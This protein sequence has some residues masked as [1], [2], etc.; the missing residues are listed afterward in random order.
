[1]DV[2][3]HSVGHGGVLLLNSTPNTSGLIPEGDLQ[4][5]AA[6][7]REIERRF[8]QPIMEVNDQRGST[9]ELALPQ[10]TLIN[11]AVI[12]EDYR[13]G[14]RI[15]EYVVEGLSEGQWRELK[16]GTSVGRKKI[17]LFRPTQVSRVR[18]RVTKYAAEPLVRSFAAFYV[19]GLSAG[20]LTTGRPTTA[21]AFHSAPYVAPMA[22]DDD[23]QTRWGCPDGTTACWLEVDLGAPTEFGRVEIHELAD[24]IRKFTL[25][26][27]NDLNAPWQTALE[28]ALRR[29]AASERLPLRHRAVCAP[30]HHRSQ[31]SADDLG[32]PS[33]SRGKAWQRCG[34]WTAAEFSRRPRRAH[35]GPQ[36]VHP[37]ARPI[38]GEVRAVQRSALLSHHCDDVALRRRSGHARFVDASRGA[39]HLQRQ[40]HR[41]SD[42]GDPFRAE[43]GN[44]RQG[45]LRLRGNGLDSPSSKRV[46]SRLCRRGEE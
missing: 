15:R 4:L 44:D 1:M 37:E 6:F 17:D 46:G 45:W 23:R 32:V 33:P 14:E 2:Y 11:Q 31:R 20:S 22:T 42:E 7:G 8:S 26:Y 18:L 34:D 12:M 29:G 36:P 3:Y 43:S 25:L 40:P 21:S 13:E 19:E 28:G 38:R 16:T 27:R 41:A 39:K 30:G 9:V 5:Y 10:S 35:A 24:R